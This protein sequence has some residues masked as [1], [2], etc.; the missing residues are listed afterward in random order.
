[1]HDLVRNGE[2][3]GIQK[4]IAKKLKRCQGTAC[5]GLECHVQGY[6]AHASAAHT[7]SNSSQ[8]LI[9]TRIAAIRP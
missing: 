8:D 4:D 2:N 3:Y 6:A 1:M 7:C 5:K 9:Y